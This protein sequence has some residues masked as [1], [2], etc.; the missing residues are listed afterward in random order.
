MI[1]LDNVSKSYRVGDKR[2]I[3]MKNVSLTF[4]RGRN[5][6]LLGRNGAGKSTLLNMI[7][8]SIMPDSGRILR[9]ARISWPLGFS[10]SFAGGLT[11][12]QNTRFVARIYGVDTDDLVAWVADFSELG[13]AIH[14]PV[15]K[16]SSGMKSR[17]AFAMSMGINFDIYLVDEITSVGDAAFKRKTKAA[18]DSKSKTSDIIMVSHSV[19]TIR[20][21]CDAA[22]ILEDGSL[23]FFGDLEE[24][25]AVH[26]FNMSK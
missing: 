24:G 11:G 26:D 10:G 15:G 23:N 22:I 3:L 16:Y 20:E 4:P 8:G 6:G 19:R 1:H 5:I 25:L 14:M 7:G 12:A 17:L 9:D 13:S 2:K 21:Y 18:F